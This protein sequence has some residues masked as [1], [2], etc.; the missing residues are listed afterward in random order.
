MVE[1]T[2]NDTLITL[3]ASIG[4]AVNGHQHT[5]VVRDRISRQTASTHF[6]ARVRGLEPHIFAG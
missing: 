4:A 1:A 2:Q 3:G 6:E 5:P